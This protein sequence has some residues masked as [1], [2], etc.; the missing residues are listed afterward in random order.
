MST[1]QMYREIHEQPAVLQH[2]LEVYQHSIQ[3]YQKQIRQCARIYL[4]GTGASLNAC[5]ASKSV[6]LRFL[7]KTPHLVTA[8]DVP[9]YTEVIRRDDLVILVSQSGESYETQ[10]AIELFQERDIRFWGM[11]NGNE[12]VL[13]RS[14][15]QTLFLHTGEEVSS[16]TKTYSATV[17]LF[18]MLAVKDFSQLE[19]IPGDMRQTLSQVGPWIEHGT[20]MLQHQSLYYVLSTGSQEATARE[21]ALT[22]KEKTFQH[23]EGMALAEFR[24]GP[25][26]VLEQG[27]PLLVVAIG[28]IPYTYVR[29]HL[30]Q[31]GKTFG[32]QVFLVT[33]QDID[34]E[35]AQCCTAVLL[36]NRSEESLSHSIAI[37]PFQLLAERLARAKG[38]DVDRFHY[39]RKSVSAY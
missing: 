21:A 10:Q 25:I 5:Y 22:L 24:H 34:Q 8:V 39:I 15:E 28:Q 9:A 16:A 37:L 3:P 33:D 30:Y 4:V 14:A 6:F 11:T 29:K 18:Y 17:M 20:E 19:H 31:F 23:V 27:L 2:L 35:T 13:A 32:A 7:R 38:L 26:E 12:S 1:T 36:E